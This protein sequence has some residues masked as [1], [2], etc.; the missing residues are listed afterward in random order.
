MA[1]EGFTRDAGV[2][3]AILHND[4]GGQAAVDAAAKELVDAANDLDRDGEAFLGD[5]YH[6]DRYVR[7]VMVP[8]QSQAKHGTGTRAANKRAARKPKYTADGVAI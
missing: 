7:P 2:I 1:S 3:A 4:P 8:A 6:T 5:P